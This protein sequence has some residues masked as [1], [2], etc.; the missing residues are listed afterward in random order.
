[1]CH[2]LANKRLPNEKIEILLPKFTGCV[3]NLGMGAE[4]LE[5]LN[6]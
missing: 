2:I 5:V 3:L 6:F 4:K 1:M